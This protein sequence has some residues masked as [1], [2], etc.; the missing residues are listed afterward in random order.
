M[1]HQ[2]TSNGPAHNQ[3]T[4]NKWGGSHIHFSNHMCSTFLQIHLQLKQQQHRLP[5]TTSQVFRCLF[6]K[7]KSVQS[8]DRCVLLEPATDQLTIHKRQAQF[9]QTTTSTRRRWFLGKCAPAWT[10]NVHQPLICRSTSAHYKQYSPA[11]FLLQVLPQQYFI[12]NCWEPV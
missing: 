8:N 6:Q 11:S 7:C 5:T 2:C 10:S 3:H 12:C 9:T 1:Y 4:G